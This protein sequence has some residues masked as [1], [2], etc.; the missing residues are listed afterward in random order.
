MRIEMD[1]RPRAV[2]MSTFLM[3]VFKLST[4]M[5]I[6]TQ[7]MLLMSNAPEMQ[8]SQPMPQHLGR[9]MDPNRAVIVVDTCYLL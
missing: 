9:P 2:T 1:T 3:V 8:W 5:L 7:D 6:N 4:I